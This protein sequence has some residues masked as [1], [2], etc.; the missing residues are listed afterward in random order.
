MNINVGQS[1]GVATIMI[2]KTLH[3]LRILLHMSKNYDMMKE[4]SHMSG[5]LD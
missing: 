2:I 5:T 4:K 3:N 1:S